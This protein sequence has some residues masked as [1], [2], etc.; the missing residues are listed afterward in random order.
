MFEANEIWL[1]GTAI[2]FTIVGFSMGFRSNSKFAVE[3]TI[4][5]LIEQGYIKSRINKDGKLELLKHNEG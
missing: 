4:D 5:L 3:K 1:I 2:L